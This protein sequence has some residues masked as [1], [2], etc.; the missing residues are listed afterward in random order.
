[1]IEKEKEFEVKFHHH[2]TI[3]FLVSDTYLD[4]KLKKNNI[5]RRT[6]TLKKPLLTMTGQD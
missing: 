3:Q 6:P 5:F 2:S 1:M 4:F